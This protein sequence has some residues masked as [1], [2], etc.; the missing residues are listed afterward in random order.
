MREIVDRHHLDVWQGQRVAHD[1]A[2]NTPQAVNADAT[3]HM[4]SSL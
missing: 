2:A 1:H 4:P 3:G